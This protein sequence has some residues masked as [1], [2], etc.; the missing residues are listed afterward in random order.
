MTLVFI[1]LGLLFLIRRIV[2]PKIRRRSS[3]FD[4]L[5]IVICLFPFVNG[6]FLTHGT[7]DSI[8]FFYNHMFVIH[9]LSG[10]AMIIM[11]VA[12]F[13]KSR[14]DSNLCTGCAACQVNCPTGTLD[15]FDKE[16][17][18]IFDYSHY[19]CVSCGEC[20]RTCPENAAELR[21]TVGLKSFFQIQQKAEIQSVQLQTCKT[22]GAFFAPEPQVEK[23][24]HEIDEDYL[25]HCPA[26]KQKNAADTF[27]Q[28]SPWAKKSN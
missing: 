9:I 28:L 5:F 21:H 20:I 10:S 7:L 11:V 17:R 6:Y 16:N 14:L 22:C 19:L 27:H 12:L 4:Y 26:C 18:R 3:I 8:P 1:G 25:V 23:I 2:F 15:Y 13:L 24:S